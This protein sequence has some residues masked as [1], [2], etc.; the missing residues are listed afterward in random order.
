MW[1][2]RRAGV[3]PY[4]GN[5][6]AWTLEGTLEVSQA[7]SHRSRKKER[8]KKWNHWWDSNSAPN[9]NEW[10][11]FFPQRQVVLRHHLGIVQFNSVPALSTRREHQ[12]PQLKDSV[13]QN[14]SLLP[15]FS[16]QSQGWAVTSASDQPASPL[17]QESGPLLRFDRSSRAT[18][19][20]Q[21]NV[22]L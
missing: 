14:C 18:H 11:F 5:I 10:D 4:S 15:H 3:R 6:T 17:T 1:H 19:R 9:S 21:K 2:I 16:R 13:L 22:Y 7:S 12:I 8:K 20:T